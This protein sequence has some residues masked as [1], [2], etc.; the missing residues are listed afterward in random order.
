MTKKQIIEKYFDV[1][2]AISEDPRNA[3]GEGADAHQPDISVAL[4]MLRA[5]AFD[6]TYG[7]VYYGIPEDFDKEAFKADWALL[8]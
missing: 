1:I 6:Q 2:K 8:D 5:T 3:I 7:D 4:D